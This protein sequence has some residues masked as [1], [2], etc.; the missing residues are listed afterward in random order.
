MKNWC[1]GIIFANIIVGTFRI[2]WGFRI[3][4]FSENQKNLIANYE[5]WIF[6]ITG[7]LLL[8]GAWNQYR[9]CGI[10]KKQKAAKETK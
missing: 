7:I 5:N 10:K 3:M 8:I 2:N 9:I 1:T 4:P 6:V